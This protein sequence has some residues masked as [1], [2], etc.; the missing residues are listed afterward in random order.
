MRGGERMGKYVGIDLGTTYSV[1]AYIDDKG[2]PQVIPNSQGQTTT[3]SAV[4]FGGKEPVVGAAAKKKSASDPTNF[5][6]FAKRHMGER[7]YTFTNKKGETYRAEEISAL[8]LDKLKEDAELFLGE[9]IDGAVI[10]VPAYFSDPQR[11]ATLQA[12]T[13]ASI[14]VL[15]MINEPTAAALA[16]GVTKNVEGT[17][18]VMIFDLGGGTF[19]VSILEISSEDIRVLATN[20]DHMLGGYDFDMEIVRHVVEAA[21]EEGV[22]I[23]SDPRAMQSLVMAAEETKKELSS[24]DSAEINLYVRGEPFDMTIERDEFEEWIEDTIDKTLAVMLRTMEEAGLEYS[25]IDKILLVGG[26]TRIPYIRR[27]I[28]EETGISP[29]YEVHPDEAVAIGAAYHVLS[30]VKDGSKP[31]NSGADDQQ[32][33]D[34]GSPPSSEG[35]PPT[36]GMEFHDVTSHGIGIV[37]RDEDLGKDVNSV[38]MP[39][40]TQIPAEIS[41]HYVTVVPMQEKFNLVVTQGEY[42]D[43]AACTII[44][45]AEMKISP[46]NEIVP[47][48]VTVSC[49]KNAIIHV[50]AVDMGLKEN[51]GEIVIN[52]GKHNMTEE[53]VAAAS[54]RLSRNKMDIG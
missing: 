47:L 11:E 20:G 19:D 39:K 23:E 9:K 18:R 8:V 43:L 53:E 21:K 31:I 48:E 25:Q 13:I 16:F 33:K 15:G 3:P 41:Q 10:T 38:I 54:D 42:E 35:L 26:S 32:G 4:L 37:V 44:G 24:S 45:E 40:N 22:E 5:E 51:L 46:R 2:N 14:P 7:S 30:L 29:S 28:E 17:L 27:M 49:D 12:G 50:R 1:I 52:R 34:A 6:A 36:P